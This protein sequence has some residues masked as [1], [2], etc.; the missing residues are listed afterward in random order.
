MTYTF[1][2]SDTTPQS[3]S[4]INMLISLSKEN[5]FLKIIDYPTGNED[6]QLTEEQEKEL[7]IRYKNFLENPRNGKPWNEVRKLLSV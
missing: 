3:E 1:Q 4:I 5:S 2:I 7:E 6:F